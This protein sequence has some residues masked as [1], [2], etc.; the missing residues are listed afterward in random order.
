MRSTTTGLLVAALIALPGAALAQGDAGRTGTPPEAARGM[1]RTT[2]M[3]G[4]G[5]TTG[6][7]TKAPGREGGMGNMGSGSGSS[8]NTGVG[9]GNQGANQGAR[10]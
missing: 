5:S 9:M 4:P 1:D 2:G 6:S 3:D 8:A 7:T 10:Q